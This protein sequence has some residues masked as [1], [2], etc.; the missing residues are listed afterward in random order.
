MSCRQAES[1]NQKELLRA[2]FLCFI[3]AIELLQP[4]EDREQPHQDPD[5]RKNAYYGQAR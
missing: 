4:D 1:A 3:K 2:L 5:N